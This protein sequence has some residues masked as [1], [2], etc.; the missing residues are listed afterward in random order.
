MVK[1]NDAQ[2]HQEVLQELK[3]DTRI[4]E[5]EVGVEVDLG[6]VTLTGTVDSY[7]KKLAALESAHRVAGVLDVANDIEVKIPGSLGRT[8]TDIA[9]AVRNAL[10]WDVLVPADNIHSTVADGWVMLEGTVNLLREQ[11]DAEQ[12]VRNLSG[13]R[14]V[15]N[16]LVISPSPLGAI[17]VKEVIE[18]ALE[19]RADREAD[20]ILVAVHNGTVTL[21]GRVGSWPEKRAILGAVSHAPGVQ[22]VEDHLRIEPLS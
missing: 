3:W 7:A 12:A 11:E 16:N 13:V 22:R 8:D 9:Q 10:E 18:G 17:E 14:G 2:I 6:V 5:T 4:G 15:I 21:S 20:R 19:R 1:K